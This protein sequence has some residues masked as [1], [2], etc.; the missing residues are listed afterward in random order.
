MK[1]FV[2]NL[3]LGLTCLARNT[4]GSLMKVLGF[5]FGLVNQSAL[6]H[7]AFDT[8]VNYLRN[9]KKNKRKRD[10]W[11]LLGNTVN[12]TLTEFWSIKLSAS[13]NSL[14]LKLY[15]A[16][17]PV[18]R[19]QC[20]VL[21]RELGAG[22]GEI[23]DK[24]SPTFQFT[25][26][27]RY[28]ANDLLQELNLDFSKP[29]ILFCLR[30]DAYYRLKGD[31]QNISVH[32]HRNVQVGEYT[33]SIEYFLAKG[34]LVV[35][36]GRHAEE[37]IE[38]E[39]RDFVDLPFINE[40]NLKG[41]ETSRTELLELA[42]YEKCKFVISTGTGMDALASMFR[43][44]VY[45]TDYYSVYN[46]YASR[47]FPLFLPKGYLLVSENRLLAPEEVFRDAF[48]RAQKASDFHALDVK[49]LNCTSYQLLNFMREIFKLESEGREPSVS[50]LSVSHHKCLSERAFR[51]KHI[52]RI[53]DHWLNS[54]M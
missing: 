21:N 49:L 2:S 47:L 46:L 48:L 4:L 22:D 3:K 14:R 33:K 35:R 45:L 11:Y 9:F 23:L 39:N 6:G 32:S 29:L 12:S 26:S 15:S 50:E 13:S 54:T 41:S 16:V 20:L 36:M 1:S 52:P 38:I 44:R 43:R 40:T 42:L 18:H 27:Q 30:D 34:F 5:R 24:C 51:N 19:Y 17:Q 8:E 53:S 31:T 10:V 25:R 28:E 37:R 7:L